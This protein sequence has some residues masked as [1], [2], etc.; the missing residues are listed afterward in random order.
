MD[1]GASYFHIT[2][3]YNKFN[4]Q[5]TGE[6]KQIGQYTCRKATGTYTKETTCCGIITIPVVAWFAPSL[7]FP[8]GPMGYDGLPGLVLEVTQGEEIPTTFRATSIDIQRGVDR[9]IPELH[10]PARVMTQEEL[11][12]HA[13]Q[14]MGRVRRN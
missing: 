1:G 13:S 11:N 10:P 14:V 6:T 8:F 9:L 5:I 4:W 2:E 3:P 7:P 12:D